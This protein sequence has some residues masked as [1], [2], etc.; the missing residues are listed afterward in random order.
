MNAWVGRSIGLGLMALT[1]WGSSG[2]AQ[3][4]T[5]R[6]RYLL[7]QQS[8]HAPAKAKRHHTNHAAKPAQKVR[9]KA[10]SA[11]SRNTTSHRKAT[12]QMRRAPHATHRALQ[13]R[14]AKARNKVQPAL[15]HQKANTKVQAQR[16]QASH[17]RPARTTRTKVTHGKATRARTTR[18]P[19]GRKPPGT[20]I[21]TAARKTQASQSRIPR[22]ARAAQHP[23]KRLKHRSA[24]HGR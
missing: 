5:V 17:V 12:L 10:H 1:L 21:R 4:M 20:K 18:N 9:K 22:Q 24:R 14:Q 16:H 11:Q 19:A 23:A 8:R 15:K 3:A 2:L 13:Q 6:E 7:E